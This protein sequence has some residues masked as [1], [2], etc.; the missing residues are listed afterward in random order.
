M[1]LYEQYNHT[2]QIRKEVLTDDG[3]GGS[4]A[5]YTYGEPFE[6]AQTV[7]LDLVDNN[8]NKHK[9]YPE[10]KLF[11]RK[12]L[13]IHYGDILKRDDDKCYLVISD[14]ANHHTPNMSSL[15]LGRIVI[16]DYI[17]DIPNDNNN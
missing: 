2:F 14:L 11:V 4:T 3:A 9:D 16:R 5:V 10:Y 13:N 8:Q 12:S 7:Q 1:S 17:E 15:D 6:G